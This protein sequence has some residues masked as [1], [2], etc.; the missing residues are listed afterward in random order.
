MK[1]AT[2]IAGLGFLGDLLAGGITVGSVVSSTSDNFLLP[3]IA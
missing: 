3:K 2:N 1:T